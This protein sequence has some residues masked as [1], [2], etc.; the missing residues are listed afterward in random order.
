LTSLVCVPIGTTTLKIASY[1]ELSLSLIRLTSLHLLSLVGISIGAI[2]FKMPLGEHFI[3]Y[4]YYLIRRSLLFSFIIGLILRISLEFAT[5][6]QL[7][8][9]FD[10]FSSLRMSVGCIICHVFRLTLQFS[11]RE[12]LVILVCYFLCFYSAVRVVLVVVHVARL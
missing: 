7:S 9:M 10:H 5:D 3:A 11:I 2:T 8:L 12:E 1:I 4:W 6:T